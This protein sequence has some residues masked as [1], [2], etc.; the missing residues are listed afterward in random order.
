[1]AGI[2]ASASIPIEKL[3]QSAKLSTDIPS[4][5]E[6]LQKL[7]D[8]VSSSSVDDI[9]ANVLPDLFIDLHT[10][11]SSPVRRFVA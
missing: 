10:D 11:R 1:M 7:K 6:N 5:L 2:M 4:K 9:G 8:V 3:I